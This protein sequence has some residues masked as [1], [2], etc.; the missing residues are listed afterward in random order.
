MDKDALVA[1]VK[2]EIAKWVV[3]SHPYAWNTSASGRSYGLPDYGKFP[4]VSKADFDAAVTE[5]MAYV[6][7]YVLT[8]KGRVAASASGR[9]A[10]HVVQSFLI[11]PSNNIGTR[12]FNYH[13]RVVN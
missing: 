12:K 9:E 1:S 4:A 13:V 11:E 5:L 3:D 8:Y 2:S 7:Q 6:H 10:G